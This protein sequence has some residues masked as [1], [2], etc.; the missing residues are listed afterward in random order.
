MALP[1]PHI[2]LAPT[3]SWLLD[4]LGRRMIRLCI[5]TGEQISPQIRAVSNVLVLELM[6]LIYGGNNCAPLP[7]HLS[8]PP[9]QSLPRLLLLQ[10]RTLERLTTFIFRR[11]SL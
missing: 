1:S 11:F 6:V 4:G 7:S 10:V 5:L 9:I 2:G 3:F 8:V